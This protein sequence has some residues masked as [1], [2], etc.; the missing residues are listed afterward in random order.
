[1]VEEGTLGIAR[2][3]E[4]AGE[5]YDSGQDS[6]KDE[7]QRR[8]DVTRESISH[9][10]DEIKDTMVNQ[11]EAVKET[12]SKTLDWHEQVKKRPVVWSA[13]AAGAGFIVGYGVAA[14]VKGPGKISVQPYKQ[15]TRR[16]VMPPA[17]PSV[18]GGPPAAQSAHEESGPGLL[19]RIQE[20]PAFDRVK[21]EAGVIGNRLVDEISKK[22]QD[23]VLPAAVAWLSGWLEGVLPSKESNGGKSVGSSVGSS[24]SSTK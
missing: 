19:Q 5:L 2:S 24:A 11:Y 3:P 20:T 13:G 8:M 6:S 23:V 7:L 22:A 9:T 16:A 14:I 10:V 17:P 4:S 1:M 15:A 18:Y 12:V 21:N